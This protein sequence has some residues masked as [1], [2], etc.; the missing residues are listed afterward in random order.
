MKP[1]VPPEDQIPKDDKPINKGLREVATYYLEGKVGYHPRWENAMSSTSLAGIAK[2]HPFDYSDKYDNI[3]V[4]LASGKDA[5]S[6]EPALRFYDSLIG[7]KDKLIIEDT[8]HVEFYWK[9]EN[10]DKAT[11]A[12]DQFFKKH[13]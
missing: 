13:I 11:I 9:D 8:N 7:P 6:L 10:G 4:F 5:Y 2:M 1:G 3:P 12:V